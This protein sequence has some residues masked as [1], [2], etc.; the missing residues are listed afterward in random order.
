QRM[1]SPTNFLLAESKEPPAFIRAKY[2]CKN[3]MTRVFSQSN[4]PI[5]PSLNE[6]KKIKNDPTIINRYTSSI[7]L[8][9]FLELSHISHLI[10]SN[11]IQLCYTKSFD[12][13][14]SI[15]EIDLT[16]G[17]NF[18]KNS[19]NNEK[20]FREIFQ[21]TLNTSYCFFTDGSK[22]TNA[23]FTGFSIYSLDQTFKL[24]FRS[25]GYSSIF[26]L[27]AMAILE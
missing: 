19:N 7:I 5:L 1:S 3:W 16:T 18:D 9:T 21:D 13:I 26:S 2:L 11:H 12:S 14:I 17:L 20:L 27:E 22:T 23:E 8:D 6:F 24:E 25:T 10:E 15:P 4:H